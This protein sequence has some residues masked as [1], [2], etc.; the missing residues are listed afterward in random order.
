MP[1]GTHVAIPGVEISVAGTIA[2]G[3]VRDG[4]GIHGW[5]DVQSGSVR[6]AAALPLAVDGDWVTAEEDGAYELHLARGRHTWQITDADPTPLPP[7]I[8]GF[9]RG[10]ESA[11]V[12]L[13]TV[14]GADGYVI[15]RSLD[16]CESWTE[17]ARGEAEL[18][19]AAALPG[20]KAHIRAR[21]SRGQVVG[22]TSAPYP[23]PGLV[24]PPPPPDG[25]VATSDPAGIRLSW[26]EVLGV[27]TSRVYRRAGDDELTLVAEVAGRELVLERPASVT[28]YLVTS[29]DGWGEGEPSAAYSTRMLD[30]ELGLLLSTQKFTRATESFECGYPEYDPWIEGQMPVLEYPEG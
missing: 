28:E 10:K 15:E 21:A 22:P 8:H 27:A 17:D 29:V 20:T 13:G 12:R 19:I 25:V 30:T 3:L 6:I 9:V 5:L 2:V 16:G 24:G 4:A 1:S 14:P 7:V 23:L 11:L 26:G 18:L